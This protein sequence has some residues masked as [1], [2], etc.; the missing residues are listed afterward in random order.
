MP[1]GEQYSHEYARLRDREGALKRASEGHKKYRELLER[2]KR[3]ELK[4][5]KT[6]ILNGFTI[7]FIEI[8]E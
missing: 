6:P 1:R 4:R 8:Q 7:K 2:V 3:G 5:V